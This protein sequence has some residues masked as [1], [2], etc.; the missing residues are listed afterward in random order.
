[1][2]SHICVCGQAA[3]TVEHFLFRCTK[4]TTHRA[5]MLQ[6]TETQRSNISFYLGGKSASDDDKWTPNMQARE[7]RNGGG[8]RKWKQYGLQGDQDTKSE[9]YM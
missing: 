9:T 4:W 8:S 7:A 2:P 3:E 5:E 1:M 6:C